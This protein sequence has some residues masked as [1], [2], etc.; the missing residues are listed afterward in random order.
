MLIGMCLDDGSLGA[1]TV[2]TPEL[3]A[4]LAEPGTVVVDAWEFATLGLEGS[5]Y[6]AGEINGQPVRLVGTLHG[7]QGFSFIYVFCSQETLQYLMPQVAEHPDL[8]T[9]L[10]ARCHDPQ[11][12]DHVVARLRH[13]YPD[14]GVYSSRDLSHQVR[15]YWLFRSRGGWC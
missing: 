4:A 14:M 5:S 2:L 12:V 11:E 3:R 13:D 7:F 8:A 1:L 10:V 15:H 9:C 6:E